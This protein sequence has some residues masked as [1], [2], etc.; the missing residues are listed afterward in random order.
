MSFGTSRILLLVL[1]LGLSPSLAQ[2][3]GDDFISRCSHL[4]DRI[5]G[6]VG[7]KFDLPA[8]TR[9]FRR[10]WNELTVK[11]DLRRVK[12]R[13]ADYMDRVY[14]EW[15]LLGD[16]EYQLSILKYPVPQAAL[17]AL[18]SAI[19]NRISPE[20]LNKL[21]NDHVGKPTQAAI[22]HWCSMVLRNPRFENIEELE[23]WIKKY[24]NTRVII[25]DGVRYYTGLPNIPDAPVGTVRVYKGTNFYKGPALSISM[26]GKPLEEILDGGEY[27]LDPDEA[28]VHSIRAEAFHQDGISV[29]TDKTVILN[30]GSYVRIYNIPRSV[31]EHLPRGEL[32]LGEYVF[33]YSIP[34]RFRVMTLPK[35]TYLEVL[36]FDEK[37]IGPF[38]RKIQRT[39]IVDRPSELITCLKEQAEPILMRGRRVTL[40]EIFRGPSGAPEGYNLEK[41]TLLG[42]QQM[43]LLMPKFNWSEIP[44][45]PNVDI[46]RTI[47]FAYALHDSG[48]PFAFEL[49]S[50]KMHEEFSAEL[51]GQVMTRAGFTMA[52]IELARA[53]IG[54]DAI[55][56]M[57]RGDESPQEAY[58]EILRFSKQTNLT[59]REFFKVQSFYY[60]VDASSYP[61]LKSRLFRE[62]NGMLVP[63]SDKYQV[64]KNL[65]DNAN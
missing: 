28:R 17:E 43:D 42:Y 52:E 18:T 55:G 27:F 33:R 3:K 6:A 5:I 1:I 46:R 11:F 65:F 51:L 39:D 29:S 31:F 13:N 32:G 45:P 35:A 61:E 14:S 24:E 53:L 59:P 2:A 57:I 7:I 38:T 23:A 34:E 49:K 58:E 40:R 64:L 50:P 12:L 19:E 30:Y 25:R 26:V 60:A 54:N 48:K 8:G 37:A 22:L 10:E 44:D 20:A 9:N 16:P 47:R 41:H 56:L 62:E 4:L 21:S 15:V 63:V 36:K